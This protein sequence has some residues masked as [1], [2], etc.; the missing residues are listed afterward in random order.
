MCLVWVIGG[1]CEVLISRVLS[2]FSQTGRS[3]KITK[4][5]LSSLF[6][7]KHGR[8]FGRAPQE[9]DIRLFEL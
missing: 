3:R 9:L 7:R 4:V 6:E 8:S 1:I 5:R 2:G